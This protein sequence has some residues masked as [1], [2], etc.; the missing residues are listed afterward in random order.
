MLVVDIDEK[1]HADRDIDYEKKGKK[2][3]KSLAT[4]LL[5]LNLVWKILKNLVE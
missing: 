3:Q 2:N 5:E 4:T 1:G